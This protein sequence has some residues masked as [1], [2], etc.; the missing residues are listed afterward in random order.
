[1]SQA[2]SAGAPTAVRLRGLRRSF[3]EQRVLDGVDLE[4]A[5]GE[6]V[7]LL[8]ASGSGKTTILRVLA[9]LDQGADGEIEVPERS[10]V[11]F[12]E[13]RLLP[14]KRVDA[15]VMLGLEPAVAAD[16]AAELLAEVGLS[17]HAR[18][19]PKTLS[20]GEAQRVALA[21]ALARTPDLLL[22][23]EPFGALDALTRIRMHALVLRLWASRRPAVLFV[24]H[25]VDEAL[26]LADRAVVLVDGR[27]AANLPISSPR[28]R[29]RLAPELERSRLEILRHLGVADL[30]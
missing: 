12:Q 25:D 2:V 28:P 26:R 9:R 15:N 19:W 18:A 29:S 8:G 21:R 3:A 24:T 16:R 22:L 7:A 30:A 11:V 5:A 14:W 10:A 6:F 13:H 20:G 4:I 1:L 27:I 23:D 17:D